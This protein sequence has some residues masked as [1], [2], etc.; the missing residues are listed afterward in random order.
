MSGPIPDQAGPSK[1]I[2]QP[3]EKPRRSS[4]LQKQK[5]GRGLTI[6]ETLAARESAREALKEGSS[7]RVISNLFHGTIEFWLLVLG[8]HSWPFLFDPAPLDTTEQG[9][10]TSKSSTATRPHGRQLREKKPAS[11][12][13]NCWDGVR[14]RLGQERDRLF[15][16]K[17]EFAD[18]DLGGLLESEPVYYHLLGMDVLGAFLKIAVW[19][20][21]AVDLRETIKRSC[22]GTDMLRLRESARKL[23]TFIDEGNRISGNPGEKGLESREVPPV[24]T[25]TQL[26]S[27]LE[28]EITGLSKLSLA[29]QL[30][31]A[32]SAKLR[33]Q[34]SQ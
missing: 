8:M 2:Q 21:T 26:L 33:A 24:A 15:L 22:D 30:A 23:D 25:P 10:N 31:I 27:G 12:E 29:L 18:R 1:R 34:Q 17:V 13:K 19:I 9:D 28:S 4:R 3:L 6:L 7:H 11:D 16:W 32:D 20:R 14:F 5:G